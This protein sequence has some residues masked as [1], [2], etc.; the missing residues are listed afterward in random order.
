MNIEQYIESGILQEYSLG[1]LSE[2]E[3]AAVERD[4][5]LYPEIKMALRNIEL[6]LQKFAEANALWPGPEL[7]DSIWNTL[8]NLNK[9]KQM[10]P[11]DLPII[12]E[13][14]DYRKWLTLVK[15]LVPKQQDED[16]ICHVIRHT[17]TIT[18]MVLA[19]KTDFEPEMHTDLHESFIILEG[20]CECY[21]G[22]RT[23]QLGPGGFTAI[24]L[25][26]MHSV[27]LL[28]P[29]VVAILQRIAM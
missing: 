13:F 9:E 19:S 17:D 22:K 23:F 1:V 11:E 10:D 3:R 6:G 18:Q 5:A 29:R 26:E 4:C 24:P 7:Q 2:Q 16:R 21:V 15:E 20:R 14:T 8:E 28:S 27:K 12:N 25:D